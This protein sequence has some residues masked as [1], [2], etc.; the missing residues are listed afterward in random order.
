MLS[1]FIFFLI[2]G[3]VQTVHTE[4]KV[5]VI[6]SLSAEHSIFPKTGECSNLFLVCIGILILILLSISLIYL[7]SK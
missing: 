2:S 7:K 3:S 4:V 1:L 6:N 5:K